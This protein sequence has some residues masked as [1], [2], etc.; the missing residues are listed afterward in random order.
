MFEDVEK[1]LG[2]G[3]LLIS[4]GIGGLFGFWP[5]VLCAGVLLFSVALLV[6]VVSLR[7]SGEKKNIA[8]TAM[9]H[10]FSGGVRDRGAA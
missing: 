1:S 8:E 5:G 6:L 9:P 10:S 7:D 2:Y 3:G 4:V